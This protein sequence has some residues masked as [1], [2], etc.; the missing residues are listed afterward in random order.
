VRLYLKMDRRER[1][2]KIRENL[3]ER[4]VTHPPETT[5]RIIRVQ[6]GVG[7]AEFGQ[8]GCGGRRNLLGFLPMVRPM[9]ASPPPDR[10]LNGAPTSHGEEILKGLR[11]VI[12]PV[13]PQAMITW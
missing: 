13:R 2:F 11:S 1:N 7:V 9:A 5:F 10:S 12:R 8:G 6:V 4:F 3:E